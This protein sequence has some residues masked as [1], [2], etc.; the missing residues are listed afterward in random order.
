MKNS[1][2]FRLTM[3]VGLVAVVAAACAGD[4]VGS[5]MSISGVVTEMTG[6]L[7]VV[8]SF[9]VLDSDGD[10]HLFSPEEGLLFLGGPLSHLRDHVLSGERVTVTFEETSDGRLIAVLIEH[11]GDEGQNHTG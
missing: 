10:S 2:S 5:E 7:S 3:V 4:A 8:Q 1:L 9:V 6:D 11:Q